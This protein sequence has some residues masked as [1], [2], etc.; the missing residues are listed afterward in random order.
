MTETEAKARAERWELRQAWWKRK[1]RWYHAV[2]ARDDTW[3]SFL[4]SNR[5]NPPPW[6]PALVRAHE[7]YTREH[8]RVVELEKEAAAWR[9]LATNDPPMVTYGDEG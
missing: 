5:A 4:I 7:A 6:W 1:G 3:T 9:Q 2:L 8:E